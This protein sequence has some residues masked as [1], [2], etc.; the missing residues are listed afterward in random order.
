MNSILIVDDHVLF[1]EGMRLII[2]HWED[3]EV[4]GEASNGV[5]AIKL[6]HTLHPDII[7]MDIHMPVMDGLEATRRILCDLPSIRIVILTMS[8]AK[9]DLFNAIKYGAQGY[10]LK[11]TPSKRLHDE[12]RRMLQG[13]TPLSGLMTTKMLE[14]FS[15]YNSPYQSPAEY[16]E[17]FT[18]REHQVLELLVEG[19]SNRQIADRIYLSEN[20]TKKHLRS[21][22]EKLHMNNRVEAAVYAVREGL[23][24]RGE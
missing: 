9:E 14:G 22:L 8:E 19:L 17:P 20:T 18:E 4:C 10:L 21:I 24:D 15:R 6:A 16:H 23:V 7:L 12:L 3:F 1:R 13:E 2:G 5:Q 11:D